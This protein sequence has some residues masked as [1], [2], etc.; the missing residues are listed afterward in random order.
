VAVS[1]AVGWQ[2]EVA[3]DPL[4]LLRAAFSHVGAWVA[5]PRLLCFRMSPSPSNL[6]FEE[7][8]GAVDGKQVFSACRRARLP[9][10]L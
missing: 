7:E 8:S 2:V 9:G 4:P 6:G 1:I 3:L 10:K 5:T